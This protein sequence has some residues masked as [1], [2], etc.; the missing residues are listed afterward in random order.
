MDSP[1]EEEEEVLD[2]EELADIEA[3]RIEKEEEAF[4]NE[5]WPAYVKYVDSLVSPYTSLYI[6][7]VSL[8]NFYYFQKRKAKFRKFYVTKDKKKYIIKYFKFRSVCMFRTY[9]RDLF[10]LTFLIITKNP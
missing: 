6:S 10:I 5:R 2:P 3:E 1:A 9:S 4:R 8:N 7:L